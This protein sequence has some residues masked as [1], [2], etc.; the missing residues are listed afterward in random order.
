M[1]HLG[2]ILRQL[3]EIRNYKQKWVAQQL[4]LSEEGLR[5]IE[6]GRTRKVKRQH[7]QRAAEIYGM[8]AQ[9]IARLLP[10]TEKPVG[11]NP[12]LNSSAV[13]ETP[14]YLKGGIQDG[15]TPILESYE[16]AMQALQA[17]LQAEQAEK[18]ALKAELQ[19]LRSEHP[20]PPEMV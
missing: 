6:T 12:T 17:S 16:R 8:S 10:T 13:E 1:S 11:P 7:L 19:A 4:G 18:D 14:K 3:R 5:K 15:F 9:E 2:Q 20:L